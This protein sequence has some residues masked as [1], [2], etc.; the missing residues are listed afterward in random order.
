VSIL[1][2]DAPVYLAAIDLFEFLLFIVT[3]EFG[4]NVTEPVFILKTSISDPIGNAT[5]EFAGIFIV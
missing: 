4:E 2:I 1:N 5:S 3:P